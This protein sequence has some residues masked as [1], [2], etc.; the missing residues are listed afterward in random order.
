MFFLIY[1][2]RSSKHLDAHYNCFVQMNY[3]QKNKAAIKL[4]MICRGATKE[5]EQI[6][7]DM[8]YAQQLSREQGY[9][10]S[11]TR[12]ATSTSSKQQERYVIF[13]K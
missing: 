13:F 4:R 7:N 10:Q 1:Y 11:F 9:Q 8:L 6:C 2:K 3:Y 5:S 12:S